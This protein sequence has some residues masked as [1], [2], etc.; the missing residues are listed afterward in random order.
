MTKEII[1]QAR[2]KVKNNPCK[3]RVCAICYNR[4]GNLL[5]IA[6]NYPRLS[7]KGG[8][9]HAEIAALQKWGIMIHSMTLLRFG[10]GGDLLPIH[11]CK[12]CQR[13][14][15]KMGIKVIG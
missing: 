2:S 14:L 15:D 5:G 10:K 6:Y 12:N 9:I 7:K 8:G 11:P 1:N 3:F 4:R 13:V